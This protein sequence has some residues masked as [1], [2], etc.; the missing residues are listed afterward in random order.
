MGSI[1]KRWNK[2]EDEMIT[3]LYTT[4]GCQGLLKRMPY[5]T[6]KSIKARAV[7]LGVRYYNQPWTEEEEQTLRDL[8]PNQ[9]QASVANKLGRTPYLV[10]EKAK[11]LGLNRCPRYPRRRGN[12]SPLYNGFRDISGSHWKSMFRSASKR[13][14]EF[15]VNI[16]YIWDLYEKQGCKCALSG[17]PIKFSSL[18]TM[19]D[20][21]ASLDRIDSSKGYIENN[22]QWVHKD[23][24]HMKWDLTQADFINYCHK[25]ATLYPKS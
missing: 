16:E 17:V 22:L 18:W 15:S 11:E 8:Y 9:N 20:G 19:R 10:R 25:V 3:S 4:E 24:N 21:T 14:I 1:R 7:R 2:E 6:L 12:A 23:V 13:N 5:R